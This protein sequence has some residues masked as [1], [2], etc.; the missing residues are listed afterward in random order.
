MDNA[1]SPLLSVE[2]LTVDFRSAEGKTVRAIE[3]VSF[4]IQPEQTM[5]LV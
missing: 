3:D 4:A 2:H 5:A 1:Q